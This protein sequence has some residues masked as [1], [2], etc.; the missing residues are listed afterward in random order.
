MRVVLVDDSESSLAFMSGLV[1]TLP[2]CEAMPF[3]NSAEA[4]L[5]CQSASKIDPHSA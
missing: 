4:L 1:K 3:Q 2:D 5:W